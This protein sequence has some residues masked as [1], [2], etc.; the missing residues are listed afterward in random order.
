M[1][2]IQNIKKQFNISNPKRVAH[3]YKA[4]RLEYLNGSWKSISQGMKLLDEIVKLT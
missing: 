1:S 3:L 2:L 4:L